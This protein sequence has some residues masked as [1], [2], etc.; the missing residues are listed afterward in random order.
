MRKTAEPTTAKKCFTIITLSTINLEVVGREKEI[1]RRVCLVIF[2][3][4]ISYI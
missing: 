4:I 2:K 3:I 1:K